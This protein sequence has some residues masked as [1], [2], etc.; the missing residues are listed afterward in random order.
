MNWTAIE[1]FLL[2]AEL[3]HVSQAAERR[4][5]SQSA[6]SRQIRGLEE[7]L[8]FQLFERHGRKMTLTPSGQLFV[9]EARD[10]LASLN[11]TN[12]AIARIRLGQKASVTLG[13]SS[14]VLRYIIAP[15]LVNFRRIEPET[16]VMVYEA[17]NDIQ[18]LLRDGKAEVIVCGKFPDRKNLTWHE[19]YSFHL[20]A[21]MH[22]GHPLARRDY[23]ELDD[24]LNEQLLLLSAGKASQ[25]L[26]GGFIEGQ[27]P[28]RVIESQNP[29][30]LLTMAEG[31]LGIAV[32]SDTVTF[33]DYRIS[34]VPFVQDGVQLGSTTY[35]AWPKG[36]HISAEAGRFLDFLGQELSVS[37]QL[38]F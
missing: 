29:E 36:R 5:I 28:R 13:C 34:A 12:Q 26:Y 35:A 23:V 4:F 20:F 2:V 18:S 15:A 30:T 31:G 10:L 33:G 24:L 19:I 25:L 37:T 6:L 17:D 22:P 3:G 7:N 21:L 14:V 27:R 38:R 9:E 11:Q 1:N 8:G 16:D 32:L